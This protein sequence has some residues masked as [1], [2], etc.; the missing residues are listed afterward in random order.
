VCAVSSAKRECL[1]GLLQFR[2][3]SYIFLL[4]SPTYETHHSKA[5]LQRA[6]IQAAKGAAS[7]VGQTSASLSIVA[8]APAAFGMSAGVQLALVAASVFAIATGAVV[9]VA[10]A[11]EHYKDENSNNRVV[12][13]A[14]I[15]APILVVMNDEPP[16]KTSTDHHLEGNSAPTKHPD[17]EDLKYGTYQ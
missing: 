17:N 15:K 16:T 2:E 12:P 7:A 6:A 10:I 8:T 3:F 13:D 9:A 5:V 4:S 1:G 11:G 14:V